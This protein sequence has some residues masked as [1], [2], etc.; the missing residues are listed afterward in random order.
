MPRHDSSAGKP[1]KKSKNVQVKLAELK[2]SEPTL[3]HA[4]RLKQI[5]DLWKIETGKKKQ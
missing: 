2:K 1:Q 4:E 3:S 5:N